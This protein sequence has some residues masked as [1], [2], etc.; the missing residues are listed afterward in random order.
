MVLIHNVAG[1]ANFVKAQFCL[2][3]AETLLA[4]GMQRMLTFPL[5]T[6]HRLSQLHL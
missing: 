3:H 6:V 5:H 1:T 4:K 2:D